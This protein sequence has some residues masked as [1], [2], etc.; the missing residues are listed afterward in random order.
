MASP[1][2]R[3]LRAGCFRSSTLLLLGI[4]LLVCRAVIGPFAL[5]HQQ[6]IA[7]LGSCD[8]A[9]CIATPATVRV[10]HG[11]FRAWLSEQLSPACQEKCWIGNFRPLCQ[12]CS[13]ID[14]PENEEKRRQ[15]G[16]FCKAHGTCRLSGP[17]EKGH[18]AC[19][20]YDASLR[21]ARVALLRSLG[22]TVLPNANYGIDVYGISIKEPWVLS[23]EELLCAIQDLTQDY[24]VV[25]FKGQKGVLCETDTAM[26]YAL[27]KAYEG[28][29][30]FPTAPRINVI[31]NHPLLGVSN[32]PAEVMEA[33]MPQGATGFSVVPAVVKNLSK[34]QLEL[35]KRIW[36]RSTYFEKLRRLFPLLVEHPITK[37]LLVYV[38]NTVAFGIDMDKPYGRMFDPGESQDFRNKL[39]AALTAH[40]FNMSWEK[41]DFAYVDNLALMHKTW[42]ENAENPE[43]A[44]RV[45]RKA[46]CGCLPVRSLPMTAAS[47]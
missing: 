42:P 32:M 44:L 22:A 17:I 30:V 47:T 11:H 43:T 21:D 23:H 6:T 46:S 18:P 33:A 39:D 15:C 14:A 8:P 35:W 3:Q 1:S 37:E 2:V 10:V 13:D 24:L 29:F 9:Q 5:R 45:V 7:A 36:W 25:N 20:A 28:K 40:S 38:H 4:G 27:G 34:E 16:M 41:G 19:P 12:D 26:C 31:S